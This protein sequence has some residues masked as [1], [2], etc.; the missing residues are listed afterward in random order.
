MVPIIETS[1]FL[2]NWEVEIKGMF[3]GLVYILKLS[4][5]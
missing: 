2:E 5:G 3:P 4:A 1:I